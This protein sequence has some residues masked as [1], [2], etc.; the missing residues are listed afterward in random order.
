LPEL[1]ERVREIGRTA[2]SPGLPLIA[3]H[4]VPQ[5]VIESLRAALD[6]AV[7]ASPERAARLRLKGFASL[8]FDD[9]TRITE[10]E[11]KARALGY[12]RLA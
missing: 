5:D 12:P 3:A 2:S 1:A 4:D 8:S 7:A 6:E 11:N 9:Y 10:L